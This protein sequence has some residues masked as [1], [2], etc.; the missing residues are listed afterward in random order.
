MKN[1]KFC[2]AIESTAHTFSIAIVDSNF[3]IYS[4][5]IDSYKTEKGGIVPNEAAKHHKIVKN[6][7]LAKA[8][9]EANISI[10]DIDVI[11]F[12]QGPGLAPCLLVGRDLAKNLALKLK[13][14]LIPVNHC[15]AHLE[16]ARAVTKARDPVLLYVSGANTQIIAYADKK[17]RVF[18][19]TLDMGVGNFLDS[20]AR[21]VGLGFPGGPKIAEL[22]EKGKNLIELPYTVKGMDVAFSGILTNLKQKYNSGKYALEDLCYSLQEYAFAMII[23]VAERAMAHL[24]KKELALG[25]GVAC[26]KRLQEM[27]IIMTKARNAKCFIPQSSLLVDNAAMIGLTAVFMLKAKEYKFDKKEI[28]HVEIKPYQRTD[29]VDVFW[30]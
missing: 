13:V 19:E 2:L 24:N 25:G 1:K 30:R 18:G 29:D 15:I 6:K 20:F 28:K 4:N 9:E 12:S 8:L 10:K 27:A 26:N 5:I 16:V 11:S 14:P 22:A 17:Y 23:E 3:K 7:V 21:Y